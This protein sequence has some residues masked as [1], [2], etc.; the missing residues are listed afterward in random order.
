MS[1]DKLKALSG[2]VLAG[3]AKT[4]E[5]ELIYLHMHSM[6]NLRETIKKLPEGAGPT[7]T[8]AE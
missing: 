2:E 4:D 5:L 7:A 3:L 8:P 1:R 6:Q